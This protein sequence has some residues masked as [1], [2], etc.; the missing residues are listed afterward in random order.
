MQFPDTNIGSLAADD[1]K[2]FHFG[3]DH[4]QRSDYERVVSTTG[5]GCFAY[6]WESINGPG[7]WAKNDFVWV[8]QYKRIA[9]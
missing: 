6:L 7:S 1:P 3:D 8:I 5:R 2:L 9:P 4:T